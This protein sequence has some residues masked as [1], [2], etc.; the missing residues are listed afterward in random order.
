[1]KICIF[2]GYKGK[3]TRHHLIPKFYRRGIASLPVR[4]PQYQGIDLNRAVRC[5]RTCH[6]AIHRHIDDSEMAE[7]YFH[8]GM[9]WTH[10]GLSL[11]FKMRREELLA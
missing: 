6:D 3:I 10:P 8:E 5:C 11:F 7:K 1:M 4:P 2:C 9:L